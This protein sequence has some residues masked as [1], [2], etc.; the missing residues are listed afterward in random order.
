LYISKLNILGYKNCNNKATISLNKGLNILVGENASGKTTIIDAI[1]MI[2]KETEYSYMNIKESDFYR[3]FTETNK[4]ENIKIDLYFNGLT[5][6][7]EVTFL[8]WCDADFN[9][10]LHLEVDRNPNRKGYY[11]KTIWGGASKASAFEEETF[12]CIDCIYLPPLRDAEEKLSN[13]RKSRLAT[14]LKH[15]YM[16]QEEKNS[17]VDK[18]SQFNQSIVANENSEYKEIAKAKNDINN[19]L[20]KAMGQVLGQSINLQFADASFISILQSIKMVFFPQLDETDITKF[21]DIAINSLGYNNLL[22]I[23][24]VFSELEAVGKDNNLFTVLLIEEP[25]AHL[26]P[27]LQIKLI[28]YLEKLTEDYK[29][30]QIIITT[31]SPVLASSVDIEHL[32]HI[33]DKSDTI[34]AISLA[35]LDLG[36]SKNFINRW[37]DVTKS[38]LLFSKGVILVEG[39]SESLL[40]SEMAK[41][42]LSKYN[43]DNS[44]DNLPKTLEE[45]GVAII[46]INGINFKHFM[47]MFCNIDESKSKIKLPFRCAGI[48]D[49]DPQNNIENMKDKDGNELVD[50]EG[51]NITKMVECYPK[52]DSIIRGANIALNLISEISKSSNTRLFSSPLKTFEYDLAMEKNT[53]MMSDV[54]K[55]IWSS[56]GPVKEMLANI[57][58]KNNSYSTNNDLRKDSIYIFKHIDHKKVGKGIFAQELADEIKKQ[59]EEMKKEDKVNSKEILHIP[60]YIYNAVIWAC[61]GELDD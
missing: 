33:S 56:N 50:E 11:K 22:Y 16:T 41:I 6:D 40:L 38:T 59:Y 13:G 43:L 2:L 32:I 54:I 10:K 31:H 42:V 5:A 36:K 14:L 57:G 45:A 9:A 52:K 27:Q 4:S 55:K 35:K 17:L 37:L 19:Y 48:T 46:N 18:V 1:R 25:E 58:D 30:M 60:T 12:E 24:T 53:K 15:Q 61:G 3:S 23:A 26:H 28:K 34:N 47:K 39:I 7:E 20:K 29:D 49:N 44:R 51:K 8:T 21:R